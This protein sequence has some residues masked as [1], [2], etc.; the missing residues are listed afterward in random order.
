MLDR[1]RSSNSTEMSEAPVRIVLADGRELNGLIAMPATT[2]LDAFIN[3]AAAF[4]AFTDHEGVMQFIAKSQIAAIRP[5]VVPRTSQLSRRLAEGTTFDPYDV[6]EVERG[7]GAGAIRQAYVMKARLYHPDRFA[8]I[9]LPREMAAYLK[10]MQQRI[11]L[12][13]EALTQ[14]KTAAA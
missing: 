14:G 1:N 5:V 2:R 13:Y 11:N 6:L 12:A 3:N 9:D 8:G 7:S 4:L 10:G